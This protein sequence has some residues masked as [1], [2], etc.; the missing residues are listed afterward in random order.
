[1][2]NLFQLTRQATNVF[3]LARQ[4]KS[5]R[6]PRVPF[7]ATR[8]FQLLSSVVVAGVASFFVFVR[9]YTFHLAPLVP[10]LTTLCQNINQEKLAVP[11]PLIFV[12]SHFHNKPGRE[13]SLAQLI[14]NQLMAASIGSLVALVLTV[15]GYCVT[16][17]NPRQSIVNDSILT[18]LWAASLG[19]LIYYTIRVLSSACPSWHYTNG[20]LVCDLYKVIF[21]FTVSGLWVTV[22]SKIHCQCLLT[23]VPSVFTLAA[24]SLDIYVLRRDR[25]Q[26]ARGSYRLQRLDNNRVRSRSATREL[27]KEGDLGYGGGGLAGTRSRAGSEVWEE[28]NID[29]AGMPRSS[30][31]SQ[32]PLSADDLNTRR[33]RWA[34]WVWCLTVRTW[35]WSL[36]WVRSSP[37][38][39]VR[40]DEFVGWGI[41][42]D[43]KCLTWES[44]AG[45]RSLWDKC[46]IRN[47]KEKP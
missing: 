10:L 4:S 7:Y 2:D 23:Y 29:G 8:M 41:G 11:W 18:L 32:R 1:M 47:N 25:K 43:D 36:L 37:L 6:Y 33:S 42:V 9:S 31:S 35:K 27:L 15:L 19:V 45:V 12:S 38:D 46:N 22:G 16:S 3:Q 34:V 14:D 30:M 26:E 44:T 17:L 13:E 28:G 21:S 24:L 40:N 20:I 39:L 5:T